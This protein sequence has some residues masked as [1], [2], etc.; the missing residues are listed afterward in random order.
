MDAIVA[1]TWKKGHTA[2]IESLRDALGANNK[3]HLHALLKKIATQAEESE[4][5][6]NRVI[7]WLDGEFTYSEVTCL[8]APFGRINDLGMRNNIFLLNR[9]LIG[10]L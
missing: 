6:R 9:T 8:S 1:K 10:L 7:S 5:Y 2:Q 4:L 3:P